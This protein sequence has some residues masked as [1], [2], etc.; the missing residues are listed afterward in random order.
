MTVLD[1]VDHQD[2]GVRPWRARFQFRGRRA[3]DCHVGGRREGPGSAGLSTGLPSRRGHRGRPPRALLLAKPSPCPIRIRRSSGSSSA[4]STVTAMARDGV[5]Q[6][7]P[8]PRRPSLPAPGRAP[9]RTTRP[10]AQAAAGVLCRACGST[11]RVAPTASPNATARCTVLSHASASSLF[12]RAETFAIDSSRNEIEL[13]EVAVGARPAPRRR[14]AMRHRSVGLLL[15]EP[16]VVGAA[17][18]PLARRL[19]GQSGTTRRRRDGAT[20]RASLS[21]SPTVRHVQ[22]LAPGWRAR[23][24]LRRS[25][26]VQV[27]RSHRPAAWSATSSKTRR[28]DETRRPA[29]TS[30]R[31]GCAADCGGPR[32]TG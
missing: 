21:S 32:G 1:R 25:P 3:F 24:W 15:H 11:S 2:G 12:V 4:A 13:A 22:R 7:E 29:P 17:P 18:R 27:G 26:D 23:A 20:S 8:A 10:L 30:R 6:R 16:T 9:P 19:P 14:A 31:R 28:L 5:V